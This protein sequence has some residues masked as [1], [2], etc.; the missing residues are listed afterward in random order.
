MSV[1]TATGAGKGGTDGRRRR[2]T[3]MRRAGGVAAVTV[4]FA[5]ARK[6]AEHPG[7][8]RSLLSGNTSK[9]ARP[10]R[11]QSFPHAQI[12]ER[13]AF[14]PANF[15]PWP[16]TSPRFSLVRTRH[17]FSLS[18]PQA[19]SDLEPVVRL[20]DVFSL[21]LCSGGPTP[22]HL[23]SLSGRTF[24]CARQ[25]SCVLLSSEDLAFCRSFSSCCWATLF[26]VLIFPILIQRARKKGYLFAR[27][28]PQKSSNASRRSIPPV[29]RSR[30]RPTDETSN[31]ISL[32][33]LCRGTATLVEDNSWTG[34]WGIERLGC[35]RFYFVCADLG[36]VSFPRRALMPYVCPMLATLV[37]SSSPPNV[38][39]PAD[40]FLL[41]AQRFCNDVSHKFRPVA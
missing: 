37:S 25:L 34:L 13:R 26:F 15:C 39:S 10:K 33:S 14:S 7:T 41:S 3:T 21:P 9:L 23:C 17:P 4:Y 1:G 24:R 5:G 2:G 8:G 29:S 35:R 11:S 6:F 31:R 32:P 28:K 38:E 22:S 16:A 20:L 30:H 12:K 27:V 19:V 18:P 36:L 40:A